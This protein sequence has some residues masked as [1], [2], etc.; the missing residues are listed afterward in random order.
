[1][2]IKYTIDVSFSAASQLETALLATIER[3]D[4]EQAMVL[5]GQGADPLAPLASVEVPTL[6]GPLTLIHP[7]LIVASLESMSM[8]GALLTAGGGPLH[9]VRCRARDHAL[10]TAGQ[11]TLTLAELAVELRQAAALLPLADAIDGQSRSESPAW[12]HLGSLAWRCLSSAGSV[13][14][15]GDLY[16]AGSLLLARG[17][18]LGDRWP[19]AFALDLEVPDRAMP[20]SR[21]PLSLWY[22]IASTRG[23]G[24]SSHC[25][26]AMRAAGLTANHRFD[27]RGRTTLLHLAAQA[28]AGAAMQYLLGMGGDPELSDALGNRAE[29]WARAA[30]SIGSPDALSALQGWALVQR[31]RSGIRMMR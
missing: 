10:I 6:R 30:A 9:G 29:D 19:E 16:L 1:M 17:V 15:E 4:V 22:L 5:L 12:Q 13:N 31:I 26:H 3:D 2:D 23:K 7:P 28:N 18:D 11:S 25:F 24:L 8:L 21:M 14:D 27:R 20:G